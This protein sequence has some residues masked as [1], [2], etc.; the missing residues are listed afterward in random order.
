[1]KST[2]AIATP[3]PAQGPVAFVRAAAMSLRLGTRAAFEHPA[4]PPSHPRL[5][6]N[7]LHVHPGEA[8]A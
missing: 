3:R 8:R 1:V 4:C 2:H 5:G 7:D 6:R